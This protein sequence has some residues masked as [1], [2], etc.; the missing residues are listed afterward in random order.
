MTK[1]VSDLVAEHSPHGSQLEGWADMILNDA[2]I[3][4][5]ATVIYREEDEHPTGWYV[6]SAAMGTM[7]N[8]VVKEEFRGQ[9]LGKYLI[10]KLAEEVLERDGCA[11]MTIITDNTLSIKLHEDAGFVNVGTV[12]YQQMFDAKT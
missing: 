9:G 12:A 8:L 2:N 4:C 5:P 1:E 7:S 11:F 6:Q 10:F 3:G